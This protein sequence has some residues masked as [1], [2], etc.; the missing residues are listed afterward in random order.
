MV[1]AHRS[2]YSSF[3]SFFVEA[4]ARLKFSDF[5]EIEHV[6]EAVDIFRAS[7]QR[8]VYTQDVVL[9]DAEEKTPDGDDGKKEAGEQ[10]EQQ[11]DRRDDNGRGADGSDHH[12]PR[13]IRMSQ[14]DFRRISTQLVEYISQLEREKEES[15]EVFEGVKSSAVIEWY[16]ATRPSPDVS[17][18]PS[19]YGVRGYRLS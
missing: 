15:G 18:P 1:H 19:V 6:R 11:G 12:K 17:S 14:Q 9:Q 8:I 3:F 4:V 10:D 5:V 16:V 7:L 2:C 13:Q